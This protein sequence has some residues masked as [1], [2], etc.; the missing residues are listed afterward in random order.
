MEPL[1]AS[2]T[3]TVLLVTSLIYAGVRRYRHHQASTD[4]FRVL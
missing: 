1:A 3:T 2:R 4:V